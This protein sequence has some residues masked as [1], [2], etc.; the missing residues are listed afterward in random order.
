MRRIREYL[1]QGDI[2]DLNVLNLPDVRK[3]YDFTLAVNVGST[4][5]L[6]K[7][8]FAVHLP[9]M[10]DS[11]LEANDWLRIFILMRLVLEEIE[12]G[13]RVFVS[14]DAGLSRSVVFSGM[15]ISAI[16]QRPMDDQLMKE[17][18]GDP[19]PALW[20]NAA[21]AMKTWWLA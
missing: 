15:L 8:M 6:P 21:D 19:L 18:G 5:F 1:W 7:D 2:S 12:H 14:C 9:M 13:G 3:K 10:D 20:R 4:N 17:V 11:R 16:R